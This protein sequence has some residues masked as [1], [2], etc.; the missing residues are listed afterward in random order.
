MAPRAPAV[1]RS[2][3]ASGA[4]GNK[5]ASVSSTR[6]VPWPTGWS[7]WPQLPQA[8]GTG[9]MRAAVMTAQ[10]RGAAVQG[11][12]RIAVRAGGDPA[13]GSAEQAWRV[14]AAI[15]EH[16]HLAA[17]REMP[18]DGLHR[19]LRQALIGGV[20]AQIDQDHARRLRQPR[21]AAAARAASSGLAPRSPASPA[22]ASPNP[23]RSAP[24]RAAP[25]STARSRAE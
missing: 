25:A 19:R 14:A 24:A 3:R 22:R 7:G 15:Q 5:R 6:S 21:A 17:V 20:L 2:S 10:L 16:D 11:H 9:A 13:A 18:P 8:A 4:C 1:S 23:A 12:A